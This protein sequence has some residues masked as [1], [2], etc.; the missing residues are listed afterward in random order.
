MDSINYIDNCLNKICFPWTCEQKS[1]LANKVAAWAAFVFLGWI[2]YPI[3]L[4]SRVFQHIVDRGK[5]YF[6]AQKI[7]FK[8]EI[9][10]KLAEFNNSRVKGQVNGI[11]ITTNETNLAETYQILYDHP[12]PATAKTLHIGCATW[13]N[14][15][16]MC[17][18]K[19][20]YG[21]I[22]DFN[23]KNV[24]FIHKTIELVK[25]SESRET[26]KTAMLGYLNSLKGSEKNI[27][28]HWDQR[29][30]PTDRL[31]Q[32]L[33]REGSWLNSDENYRFIKEEIISKDRLVPI[34]EDITNFK[35]F[36]SLRS[37]ADQHEIAIDTVY[38]S[39]ICNFMSRPSDKNSFAKS[40]RS[41]LNE[42]TI[43]ISCPELRS[44]ATNST[45]KLSQKPL[46]GKVIL[47][48]TFATEE[49][50]LNIN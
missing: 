44:Q 17:A 2:C 41:V 7:L 19:S 18:R 23:P 1:P 33:L 34:T 9:S 47:D 32:E 28:F 10:Q 21:L 4:T 31:E 5:I 49:L 46:L 40:I 3:Y 13:H 20:T 26:F 27:Y 29:G 45:V 30:L 50:F 16:I 35:Q 25:V 6:T 24:E 42:N 14:L 11:Y 39:N 37:F 36:A 48:P 8:D 15:D 43:F 12:I 38:L 22:V